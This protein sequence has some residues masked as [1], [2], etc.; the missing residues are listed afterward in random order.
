MVLHVFNPEHDIALAYNR[1]N[2][3]APRAGRQLRTDL[4]FLPAIW[5]DD[6][7]VVLVNDVEVARNAV[8]QCKAHM[9]NVHFVT[10]VPA[11]TITDVSVWGWDRAVCHQLVRAGVP[12]RLLPTDKQLE[13]IRRLS[14]RSTAVSL[15]AQLRSHPQLAHATVGRSRVCHSLADIQS[16]LSDW[17]HI[18][19][20]SPWSSSGR[21]IKYVDGQLSNSQQ[22]W[23]ANVL[24]EQGSIVA[25]VFNNKVMDFGMEFFSD[26]QGHVTYC[27]LSL[28]N[29][30]NGAYTGNIVAPEADK[31]AML[32]TYLPTR[33]THSVR[34][35]LEA[36][37]SQTIGT[38]Y[39]GP[40]GIDMMVVSP[41]PC[42]ESTVQ[43]S[44]LKVQSSKFNVPPQSLCGTQP[45]PH[46]GT[47][48]SVADTQ[49]LTILG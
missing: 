8:Q 18:V 1:P 27:G 43:S 31:E 34:T 5:A 37:L 10:H 47:R 49:R 16:A 24:H 20:K 32:A 6:G 21:G 17:Q 44:K 11:D 9:A 33:L 26:G 42:S 39:R 3:T 13:T 22:G 35:Q 25:E 12:E 45:A 28:F 23:C 14:H 30:V 48:G 36:L 2:F 15:L 41:E 4:G 40:L 46:H 19:L 29:T 38:A 7:D